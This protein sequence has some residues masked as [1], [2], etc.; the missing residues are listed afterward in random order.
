MFRPE[1]FFRHMIENLGVIIK[2]S[3]YTEWTYDPET[4]FVTTVVRNT[5]RKFSVLITFCT[6]IS[7]KAIL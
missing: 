3:C 5:I 2:I 6:L 1:L 4:C 7:E